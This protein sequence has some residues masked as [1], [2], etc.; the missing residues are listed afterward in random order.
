MSDFSILRLPPWRLADAM[1]L[2]LVLFE[3]VEACAGVRAHGAV[4]RSRVIVQ[5]HVPT[6]VFDQ[7]EGLPTHLFTKHAKSH[8]Q[9]VKMKVLRSYTELAKLD[10]AITVSRAAPWH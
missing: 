7:G 5:Q 8:V 10:C 6:H 1:L 3:L 2:Q 4:K 9:Y